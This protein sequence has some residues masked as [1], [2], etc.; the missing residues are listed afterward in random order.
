MAVDEG[1]AGRPRAGVVVQADPLDVAAVA[2]RGRVVEA[3]DQAAL[4]LIKCAS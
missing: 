1:L 2:R 3:E 4:A